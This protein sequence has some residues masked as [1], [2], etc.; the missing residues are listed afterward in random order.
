M[1]ALIVLLASTYYSTCTAQE[2][3]RYSLCT[4][5]SFPYQG[6]D[7]GALAI[8][9]AQQTFQ[10]QNYQISGSIRIVD[11]CSFAIENLSYSGPAND[12]AVWYGSFV[13]WANGISLT[14]NTPV[15][16]NGTT[17]RQVFTFTQRAGAPASYNDFNEF[18]LFTLGS[19]Q[20]LA[21]VPIPNGIP[22]PG[23]SSSV[24]SSRATV[25]TTV[26][27]TS[28][29]AITPSSS[30]TPVPNTSGAAGSDVTPY[31]MIWVSLVAILVTLGL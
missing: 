4:A 3:P 10:G 14:D 28:G 5:G 11:R 30:R 22:N 18:R 27:V 2:V 23:A 1:N 21:R 24:V 15:S 12:T 31:A 7:I 16:L 17:A 9:K 8:T 19:N 6:R 20:V 13:G 26:T 25:T 29:P